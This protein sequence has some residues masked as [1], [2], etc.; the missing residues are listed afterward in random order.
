MTKKEFPF[1]RLYDK[2]RKGRI[3]TTIRGETSF[4]HHKIGSIVR[5]IVRGKLYCFAEIIDMKVQKIHEIDLDLLKKDVAPIKC[6]SNNDFAKILNKF[7][8][9]QM[10]QFDTKVTIFTLKRTRLASLNS[11]IPQ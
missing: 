2:L 3:F 4:K 8:H 5:I 9:W 11:F 6:E 7:W 1:S 10:V